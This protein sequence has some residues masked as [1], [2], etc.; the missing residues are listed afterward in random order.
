MASGAGY[1]LPTISIL[2]IGVSFHV[3]NSR[4]KRGDGIKS[5]TLV[6]GHL[7]VAFICNAFIDVDIEFPCEGIHFIIGYSS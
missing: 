7:G 2:T 6:S 3:W 1:L 4:A 5:C